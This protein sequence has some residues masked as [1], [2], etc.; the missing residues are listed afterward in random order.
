MVDKAVQRPVVTVGIL[1]HQAGDEVGGD[2][3]DKSLG[4]EPQCLRHGQDG[5]CPGGTGPPG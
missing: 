5:H 3:D 4:A 1:V 2:S